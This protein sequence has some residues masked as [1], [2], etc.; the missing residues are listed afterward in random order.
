MPLAP[1]AER[2]ARHKGSLGHLPAADQDTIAGA[3][4]DAEEAREAADVKCAAYHAAVAAQ[5]LK[6]QQARA[7][8]ISLAE[9]AGV[10]FNA[11]TNQ[12][13]AV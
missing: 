12:W 11:T 13:E 2:I 3:L 7:G 4:A 1:R 9:A 10:T 5:R 8:T 6:C